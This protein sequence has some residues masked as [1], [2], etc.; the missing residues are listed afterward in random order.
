MDEDEI[1]DLIRAERAW[2]DA[3]HG[4]PAHDDTHH[5]GD[6]VRFMDKR[7]ERVYEGADAVKNFIEIA[8][9]AV[10]AL[11]SFSRQRNDTQSRN[12]GETGSDGP[13]GNSGDHR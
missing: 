11:E 12:A 4:G 5:V 8:A 13:T 3:K 6:W 10:A 2:Q 1:F 9:L 7:L